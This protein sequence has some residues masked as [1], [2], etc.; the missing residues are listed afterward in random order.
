MIPDYLTWLHTEI[1]EQQFIN[2]YIESHGIDMQATSR[3]ALS[4]AQPLV[5]PKK[6]NYLHVYIYIYIPQKWLW[7]LISWL[8][9]GVGDIFANHN[10]EHDQARRLMYFLYCKT[11][12]SA[13]NA[14]S[15]WSKPEK[16]PK[17]LHSW[18][19]LQWKNDG[20]GMFKRHEGLYRPYLSYTMK[21]N[22]QRITTL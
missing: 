9:I 13:W 16:L 11:N 4:D 5:E 2:K 8:H 15:R 10:I 18:S 14:H 1:L 19:R 6:P 17:I 21:Y 12:T 22:D 7:K 3:I 20:F